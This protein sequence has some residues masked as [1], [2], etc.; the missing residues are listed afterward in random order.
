[1]GNIIT[2]LGQRDLKTDEE[3]KPQRD[4][5]L[6]LVASRISEEIM[7]DEEDCFK[8]RLKILHIDSI[9]DLKES[10]EIKFVK[11]QTSSQ[12]YRWRIESRLGKSEYNNYMGWLLSNS[13]KHIEEY[14]EGLNKLIC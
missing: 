11:G 2:L 5:A 7:D 1:M 9:I 14:L 10:K 12:K 4:Y 8:Y 6:M 3:I 13:D